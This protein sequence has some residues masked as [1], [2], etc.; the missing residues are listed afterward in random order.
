M[1]HLSAFHFFIIFNT[2]TFYIKH[3]QNKQRHNEC[4]RDLDWQSKIFWVTFN[5]FWNVHH[6]I[7]AEVKIGSS[8]KPNHNNKVKPSQA[9]PN[10]L[11][12]K[13]VKFIKQCFYNNFLGNIPIDRW[14]RTS[15]VLWAIKDQFADSIQRCCGISWTAVL[16]N[17]WAFQWLHWFQSHHHA[18]LTRCI[19]GLIRCPVCI[20]EWCTGGLPWKW[21]IRTHIWCTKPKAKN[22]PTYILKIQ[23]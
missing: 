20:A 10:L 23:K 7:G 16:N 22:W 14:N 21:S 6:F 9:Y 11:Y 2:F 19:N 13:N 1:I 8:L 12:T 18:A 17:P 5:H 4:V 3:R 15:I